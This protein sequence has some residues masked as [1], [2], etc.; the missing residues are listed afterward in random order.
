M[1]IDHLILADLVSPRPDGKIDIN[2]AGWDT[3]VAAA[4]P[5]THPRMDV[6]LRVLLSRHEVESPHKLL[7]TLVDADG[8]ELTRIEGDVQALPED[9]RAAL[10]AG[11]RVGIGAILTL[12]GVTFPAYGTYQLAVLWDGTEQRAISLFVERPP[13]S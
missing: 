8:S 12:A 7:V 5:T 9:Q 2:G 1:E 6:V 10:P 4:V 13:S 11:R 3:L